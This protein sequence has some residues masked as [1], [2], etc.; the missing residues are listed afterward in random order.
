MDV[1]PWPAE[2]DNRALLA[3]AVGL[4]ITVDETEPSVSDFNVD[5]Y[6]T[7]AGTDGK[8]IIENQL[9]VINID[10][11]MKEAYK[12]GV[13]AAVMSLVLKLS[14]MKHLR[15]NLSLLIHLN[16]ITLELHSLEEVSSEYQR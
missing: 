8:I 9:E 4:E 3:D 12:A 10:L 1:T 5:I 6:A 14:A 7:E 15:W 11:L 13:T 16:Q 2:D